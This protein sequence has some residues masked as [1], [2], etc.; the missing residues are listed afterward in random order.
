LRQLAVIPFRG[1][2]LP[3]AEIGASLWDMETN[4]NISA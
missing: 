2:D 1:A 3:L 4:L